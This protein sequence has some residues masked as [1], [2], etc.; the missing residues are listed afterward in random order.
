MQGAEAAHTGQVLQRG[1]VLPQP[2][3]YFVQVGFE[4]LLVQPVILVGPPCMIKLLA[5]PEV[6][7]QVA[8]AAIF[9]VQFLTLRKEQAILRPGYNSQLHTASAQGRMLAQVLRDSNYIGAIFI[10]ELRR[11]KIQLAVRTQLDGIAGENRSIEVDHDAFRQLAG[12]PPVLI[13]V[14]YPCLRKGGAGGILRGGGRTAPIRG[15]LEAAHWR[16]SGRS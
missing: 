3:H 16:H 8:D 10:H 12:V 15:H 1:I 2:I 13:G 6:P 5:A 9:S 4:W 7:A 14:A 11:L